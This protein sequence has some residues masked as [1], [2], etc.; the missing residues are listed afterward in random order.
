PSS[1][2]ASASRG[3]DSNEHEG[4]RPTSAAKAGTVGSPLAPRRSRRPSTDR[5]IKARSRDLRMEAEC[6]YGNHGAWPESKRP[7]CDNCHWEWAERR[8]R[9]ALLGP[10]DLRRPEPRRSAAGPPP[11]PDHEEHD[12]GDC[13]RDDEHRPG[14]IVGDA[15]A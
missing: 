9:P 10:E 11:Q 15:V 4:S 7:E 5:R 14:G 2:G 13:D 1:S 6:V 8:T 3:P 12:G